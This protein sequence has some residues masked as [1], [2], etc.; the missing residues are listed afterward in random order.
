MKIIEFEIETVR[1]A[2]KGRKPGFYELSELLGDLW[3]IVLRQRWYG[4][5]FRKA[6]LA[7]KIKGVRWAGQKSNKHHLY[8]LLPN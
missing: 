5:Q 3:S 4:I 1:A 2:I 8:E 7:G 6:V